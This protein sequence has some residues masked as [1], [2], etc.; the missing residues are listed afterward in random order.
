[1][2]SL[3]LNVIS[4]TFGQVSL[5]WVWGSGFCPAPSAL[6]RRDTWLLVPRFRADAQKPLD[7]PRTREAGHEGV[8]VFANLG[9]TV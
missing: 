1:M 3:F 9:L 4:D 5:C 2:V 7:T 8:E 6:R